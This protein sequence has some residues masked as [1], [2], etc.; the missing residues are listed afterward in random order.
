MAET[1]VLAGATER[2]AQINAEYATVKTALETLYK[3]VCSE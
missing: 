3:E 2:I 1:G